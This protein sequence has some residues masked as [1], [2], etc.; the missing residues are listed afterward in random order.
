M[1]MFTM[2]DTDELIRIHGIGNAGKVQKFIDSEVLRLSDPYIP[3]DTGTLAR[4]GTI[5]TVIGSGNVQYRT[6]YARTVYYSN[7]GHGRN[8]MAYGGL[9]GKLWFERMKADKKKQILESA[10]RYADSLGG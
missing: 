7:T 9:R 1:S 8:G 2:R 5:H 6:P 3:K 4:S 10:R